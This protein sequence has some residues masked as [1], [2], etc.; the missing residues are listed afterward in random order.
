MHLR[1]LVRTG[2]ASLVLLSA[3]LASLAEP[4]VPTA[5]DQVL[6]RLPAASGGP[7]GELEAQRAALA[8]RPNDL[9]LA[10]PVALAYVELG[11]READPRYDGYAQATLAPW[12][13]LE[14][15]PV[16]VLVLRATLHQR[17]HDF[18][19]A[20][21]DLDRV[22]AGSAFHQQALLTK[23]TILGVQGKP[24]QALLACEQL[25]RR[26]DQLVAAGCAAGAKGLGG[27]AREGYELLEHALNAASGTELENRGWVL[28]ILAE[29]AMQLGERERAERH[30][31][32]ALA[33]GERDPYLLGAYADFVLGEDRAA[34]VIPLLADETR[35]DPL[36]LRL[37]LA[38]QALGHPDLERHVAMLEARF[39]AARRRNDAVH[40]REAARFALHLQNRPDD[41]LGMALANFELQREPWDVRLVLEAALAAS[42][43]E[44]AAPVLEWLGRS[45]L[46][47]VRIEHLVR[48]LREEGA[49]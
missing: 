17:R 29:L 28:T 20:L 10:W 37:A 18:P 45:G 49:T 11:R 5:D 31:G 24:D 40:L 35:I 46:Q 22:P 3:P 48:R 8:G 33:L 44:A 16:P 38:E 27:R 47:D 30:F 21:A 7:A 4:F 39:A 1:N 9:R 6:E 25:A 14:K 42:R 26:V 15:P 32:E 34:E 23:A 2:A 43:P 13:E 36:L 19:Q 12:W 41:A